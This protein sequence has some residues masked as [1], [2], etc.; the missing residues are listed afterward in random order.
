MASKPTKN[1]VFVAGN[2]NW[3]IPN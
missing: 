2:C 3:Q 1:A